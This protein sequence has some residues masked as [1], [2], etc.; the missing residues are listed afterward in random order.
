M[1][2]RKCEEGPGHSWCSQSWAQT[3]HGRVCRYRV[4]RTP[5][6]VSPGAWRGQVGAMKW[7]WELLIEPP[8][9][10][11]HPTGRQWDCRV[12]AARTH[13]SP[14]GFSDLIPSCMLSRFSRVQLSCDPMDY[15]LTG[16]S[17]HEIF[18]ARI[19]ELVAIPFSQ[20][21]S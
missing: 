15:S 16:S 8:R 20:G 4:T 14:V 13:M 2:H 10:L 18:Q 21:S 3:P 5:E 12:T 17:V 6:R 9:Q 1:S 11:W 7:G 19:L